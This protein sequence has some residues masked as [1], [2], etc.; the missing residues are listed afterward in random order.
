MKMKATKKKNP[1][2]LTGR[3]NNA[4]K[5]ENKKLVI[6]LE[7]LEEELELLQETVADV[8]ARLERVEKRKR[9]RK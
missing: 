1:A 5:S 7:M 3:N 2:D 8:V 6:K 4:R 9:E